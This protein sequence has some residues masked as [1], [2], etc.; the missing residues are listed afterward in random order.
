M[1]RMKNKPDLSKQ[2]ISIR[3][4]Q[5]KNWIY[6]NNLTQPKVAKRLKMP[7]QEMKEKLNSHEPFT[8][9]QIRNLVDLMGADRAF[10]VMFFPTLSEKYRVYY[11]AFVKHKECNER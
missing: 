2:K 3:K 9:E 8:E 11:E 1:Q 4:R 10:K 6:D 7:L 5:F